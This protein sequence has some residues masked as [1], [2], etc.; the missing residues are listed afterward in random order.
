[1]KL[2]SI[3]F[4]RIQQVVPGLLVVLCLLGI[5]VGRL[6]SQNLVLENLEISDTL[7]LDEITEVS[8]SVRNASDTGL[9]GNLQF[10]FENHSNDSIA[11]PLGAFFNTLQ[12]FAPGQVREFILPIEVTP[13][14]FIEGGNTVVIWPSMVGEPRPETL[15]TE[16]VY[17]LDPNGITRFSL[18]EKEQAWLINPAEGYLRLIHPPNVPVQL[19]L[20]DFAGRVHAEG[21]FDAAGRYRLEGVK[22]GLYIVLLRNVRSGELMRQ[23]ILIQ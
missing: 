10:W 14:F 5:D 4:S 3:N 7:L 22:P 9:S 17:V 19:A 6:K 23:R 13:D 15:N 11:M 21:Q 12:F 8:F 18:P 1:M 16:E 2:I 20:M